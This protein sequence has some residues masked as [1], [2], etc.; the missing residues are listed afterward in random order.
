MS[1][2]ISLGDI[3]NIDSKLFN[4]LKLSIRKI[5]VS[6]FFYFSDLDDYL[7]DLVSNAFI[8]LLRS[9]K[10]Y[11]STKSSFSTYVYNRIYSSSKK[12]YYS[13]KY[14][15]G[16]I[17]SLMGRTKAEQEQFLGSSLAFI[18]GIDDLLYDIEDVK[19]EKFNV[20]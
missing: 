13:L 14:P 8:V 11:E 16:G 19:E 5:I 10:R 3:S 7:D 18:V 15:Y 20:Y 6:K 9:V 4:K 1:D 2:K 17:K 12:L